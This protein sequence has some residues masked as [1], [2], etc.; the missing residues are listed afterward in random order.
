MSLQTMRNLGVG[1]E[2]DILD[3]LAEFGV[4]FSVLS[5]AK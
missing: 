5:L 2:R 1:G 4:D 3:K